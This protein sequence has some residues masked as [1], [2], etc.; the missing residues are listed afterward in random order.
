M[1]VEIITKEDL[2]QFKTELLSDIKAMITPQEKPNKWLKSAE[3]RKMLN[4]SAGTLQ[5][6]RINGTLQFTKV[7]GIL[8][9]RLDD[10]NKLL[11]GGA[12]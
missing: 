9:Y 8:Y 7:G 10:I 5:N 11:E 2:R 6:L 12:Q 3:V 1:S 4:V